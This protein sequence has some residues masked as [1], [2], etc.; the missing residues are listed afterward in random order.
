MND[1]NDLMTVAK[2]HE[3]IEWCMANGDGDK[4][5]QVN[6]YFVG[7]GRWHTHLDKISLPEV[8]VQ[9]VMDYGDRTGDRIDC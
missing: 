9:D 6:E 5:V 3:I 8:H 4:F 7:S 2:L 1:R